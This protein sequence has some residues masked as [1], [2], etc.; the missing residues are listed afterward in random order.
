VFPFP[1][2]LI[3]ELIQAYIRFL[4]SRTQNQRYLFHGF[5]V[6]WFISIAIFIVGEVR[7]EPV[8]GIIHIISVSLFGVLTVAIFAVSVYQLAVEENKTREKKQEHKKTIQENLETATP[9]EQPKAAWILAKD[10]LE[11]Y[12]NRNLDQLRNIFR[13]SVGAFIS[14]FALITASIWFAFKHPGNPLASQISIWSGAIVSFISATFLVV[15]KASMNEAKEYMRV[16]ERINAVGMA[17]SV[18]ESLQKKEDDYDKAL[19]EI[20]TSLLHMY[21]NPA[22]NEK[23]VKKKAQTKTPATDKE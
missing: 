22:Q 21:G 11:D 9:Q 6:F 7:H 15:Y 19:I 17:V 3:G 12:L 23:A 20:S 18:L 1:E 4:A 2:S 5:T 13:L 14:G 16:L 10:T 8:N